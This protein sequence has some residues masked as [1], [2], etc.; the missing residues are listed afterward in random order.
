[1]TAGV[2]ARQV[3][4]AMGLP[5]LARLSWARL[6]IELKQFTRNPGQ[7][8]FTFSLPVLFLLLFGTIFGGETVEAPPGERSVKFIQYFVPGII[9]AGA[10]STTFTNLALS[11]AVEQHE[12]LLKRLAG[13]PLP[14]TAYFA[15]KLGMAALTTFAQ[16]GIMLAV[17]VAFYDVSLPPD[18]GHWAVFA[19]VL[20]LGVAAC[21]LLGIAYTR[22]IP[23]ASS[24]A[25]IVQPPFL[26]LQFI[27]GVFFPYSDVP[28]PCRA[29]PRYSR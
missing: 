14:R 10:M 13:T 15:G 22:M 8:F 28:A 18:A 29:S 17:A 27:S 3:R 1:M 25:A 11:I 7:V 4:A 9:A 5:R 24:A 26:I 19:S 6:L 2:R 16:T 23:N 12:G 21:S 20:L